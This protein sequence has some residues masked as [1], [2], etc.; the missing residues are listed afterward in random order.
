MVSLTDPVTLSSTLPLNTFHAFT[1]PMLCYKQLA[2]C[3]LSLINRG[4]SKEV[5]GRQEK[6]WDFSNE[7]D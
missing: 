2:L 7:T 1:W 4:I 6:A 5:C 3:N